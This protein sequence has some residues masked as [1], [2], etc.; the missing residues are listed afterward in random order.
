MT[1]LANFLSDAVV[2]G[3]KTMGQDPKRV[4]CSEFT[5]DDEAS[6]SSRREQLDH[7]LAQ[8]STEQRHAA[9]I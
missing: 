4:D 8:V 5:D 9:Y 7:L 1:R 3:G 2:N 6:I